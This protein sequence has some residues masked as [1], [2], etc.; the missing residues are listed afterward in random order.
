MAQLAKPLFK[1]PTTALVCLG[2]AIGILPLVSTP[3]LAAH[4][5]PRLEVSTLQW[6][7]PETS[8]APMIVVQGENCA[9]ILAGGDPDDAG[10]RYRVTAAPKKGRATPT[11]LGITYQVQEGFRGQ[12]ALTIEMLTRDG[13]R[14]FRTMKIDVR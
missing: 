10:S 9:V 14:R 3:A 13:Q 5:C 6:P 4:S 1:T 7:L 2:F 11:P 12:D 8:G